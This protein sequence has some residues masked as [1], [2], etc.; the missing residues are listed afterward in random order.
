MTDSVRK[1]EDKRTV[2]LIKRINA[3]DSSALEHLLD[4]Y[5]PQLKAFFRHINVSEACIDDLVQDTFEKMLTK[6]D[7]FDSE[8]KFYSWL[9]V[10][11]KNLYIDQYRRKIKCGE[12]L[13]QTDFDLEK[14]N[15]P[16]EEAVGNLSVEEIL[17]SLDNSERYIVELRVFKKFSFG[18]I[19][20]LTGTPEAT[21]RSKFFRAM[22]K[23]RRVL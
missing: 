22:S 6:L 12:I 20:E 3:G 8:K 19:S 14:A 15:D 5:I 7:T 11:G 9:M 2:E 23:L 13:S 10:I 18:D 17:R 1:I 4:I 21:L 16:E